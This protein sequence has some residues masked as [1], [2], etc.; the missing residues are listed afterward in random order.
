MIVHLCC[1]HFQ[2][3][4]YDVDDN[5]SDLEDFILS[6]TSTE[7]LPTTATELQ[8]QTSSGRGKEFKMQI[9]QEKLLKISS[10]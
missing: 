2:N 1:L 8:Q 10:I 5:M 9:I 3:L 4:G 7:L 6:D